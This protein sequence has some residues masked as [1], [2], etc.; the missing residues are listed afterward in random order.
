[1]SEFPPAYQ[2]G[3]RVTIGDKVLDWNPQTVGTVIMVDQGAANVIVEW[4]D[5]NVTHENLWE[6][7]LNWYQSKWY[8]YF[9]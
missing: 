1:M 2:E 7:Q 5:G 9:P 4:R 6:A 3:K 8:W